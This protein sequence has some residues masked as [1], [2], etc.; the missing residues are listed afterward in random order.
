MVY[1]HMGEFLA[2]L[3]FVPRALFTALLFIISTLLTASAANAQTAEPPIIS[4]PAPSGVVQLHQRPN[5][6]YA[7]RLIADVKADEYVA[8]WTRTE[9]T[10]SS[11][12]EAL[13]AV[14]KRDE[15]SYSTARTLLAG[16][17]TYKEFHA[18][19]EEPGEGW[20][21]A[22]STA[23]FA[24]CATKY[25][26][27]YKQVESNPA[28]SSLEVDIP[29]GLL[30]PGS[31]QL[32]IVA[33][34]YP[35]ERRGNPL[36]AQKAFPDNGWAYGGCRS[37][38]SNA[39]IFSVTVPY[40]PVEG[41][42]LPAADVEKGT[43]FDSTVF[44]KLS[45]APVT[46]IVEG[47][48]ETLTRAG[49]T[50]IVA[51]VLAILIA[52]PTELVESTISKNHS[53]LAGYT[54]RLL[55]VRSRG[56]R[57]RPLM[58]G[59]E[60]Q[61]NT[62]APDAPIGFRL[63]GDASKWWS[64][65]VLIAG[66]VIAGFAEPDFGINWMSLRLVITMFVAFL[67]VNL[68]GTFL[69]WLITRRHTGSEKPRLKARPFYLL[70]ILLTVLFARTVTI[71]PALVFGTLLAIDYGI[72]LSKTRSAWATIIGAAYAIVLGLAAWVGYTVIAQFKLADVENL[73]QI[74]N[75][76]TFQVYTAIS[77][78][79]TG[80][81]ELASVICVQ[82]LSTV[83]IA[84]LPL[85]FLSGSA[86]WQWNKWVWVATYA[87][88][89]AA[90][91]F[92]LVPL[93]M[94]WEGISQSLALWIGVLLT[95]AILAVGLW[96]YFRITSKGAASPALSSAESAPSPADLEMAAPTETEGD[97]AEPV[98]ATVGVSPRSEGE[99]PVR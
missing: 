73:T 51:L 81:G 29:I 37:T 35:E 91:S 53:R 78:T 25:G 40:A 33:L 85:A 3:Y 1:F 54:R 77:F 49:L 74:D 57:R 6:S 10:W 19:D 94:A 42:V 28:G 68:G 8:S 13:A 47:E 65:P 41:T 48:A 64:V 87:V 45:E 12:D 86:L 60:H 61:P 67:I 90:Y 32:F 50:T 62:D 23:A 20:T 89:L 66:S 46:G 70:L 72:R 97:S 79:Q 98:S 17:N 58:E 44:S 88:G 9:G 82:A 15:C 99:T 27:G 84:L 93:P 75:Q 39:K 71:E 43:A 69:T 59:G 2:R 56:S 31:H 80:L 21:T 26:I 96:A 83:P 95:Y 18:R 52:L 34:E 4:K 63:L 16:F 22:E 36:C 24:A 55:P 30:G 11:V 7:W 5:G 76:Y 14:R 38:P 92:V